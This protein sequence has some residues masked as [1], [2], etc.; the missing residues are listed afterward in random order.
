MWMEVVM[1]LESSHHAWECRVTG[2]NHLW[3]RIT[4]E[5]ALCT[6]VREFYTYLLKMAANYCQ[7]SASLLTVSFGVKCSEGVPEAKNVAKMVP[8]SSPPR[9]A[10]TERY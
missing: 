3:L 1:C 7:Y 5:I 6:I 2:S 9:A 4:H 10:H 8:D